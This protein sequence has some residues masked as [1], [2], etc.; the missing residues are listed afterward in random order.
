MSVVIAKHQLF[1][2]QENEPFL[3]RNIMLSSKE[4]KG[5]AENEFAMEC[6]VELNHWHEELELAY[7]V[8]SRSFH[9][10]DGVCVEG[11]P[12]RLIVTNSESTHNI[13]QDTAATSKEGLGAVVILIDAK[14]LE[15]HFPEYQS[16]Y[17]INEK[18]QARPEI[19]DIIM[20][21]SEYANRTERMSHDVLYAKGL[22][23]QLLYYMC[24]EGTVK[25]DEF[26]VNFKKNMER[27]KEVLTYLEEHYAESISQNQVAQKFY[28]NAEYF[29]RY[30]KRCM[31][32]TFTEYL[33]RYRLQ[34]ARR[35]LVESDKRVIDIAMEHG[36]SDDRRF[37]NAFKKYYETTPLQY[38]KQ[39]KS[40][41]GSFLSK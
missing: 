23:L 6:Y 2:Y 19:R 36:F 15:E 34:K 33:V 3:V 9:Y 37:I 1:E 12:G 5:F 18:T 38:R 16:I 14:F 27:L 7:I 11:I 24:E 40:K 29:S 13:I 32:M 8:N 41:C 22:I 28:F 20:K 30:F 26:G 10:I 31:G 25:R 35:E 17:F 21:L 4:R 39:N